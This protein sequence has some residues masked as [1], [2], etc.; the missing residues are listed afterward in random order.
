[1]TAESAPSAGRSANRRAASPSSPQRRHVKLLPSS[2]SFPPQ[3]H[4]LVLILSRP[5]ARALTDY[6]SRRGSG[7]TRTFMA[8][9]SLPDWGSQ[10]RPLIAVLQPGRRMRLASPASLLRTGGVAVYRAPPTSSSFH[11]HTSV[12]GTAPNDKSSL[13]IRPDRLS[14]VADTAPKRKCS[15]PS[16]SHPRRENVDRGRLT[17]DACD[18]AV[19]RRLKK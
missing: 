17:R 2:H 15:L 16:V 5:H 4:M 13:V 1:M 18:C 19:G 3:R 6:S 10:D 12:A 11:L 7:S 9:A 8:I 14:I